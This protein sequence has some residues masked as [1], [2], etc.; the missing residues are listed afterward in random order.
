MIPVRVFT[1][2]VCATCPMAIRITRRL[3]DENPD[4]DL[5][6]VSLGSAR[7]REEAKAREV[8]SVPTVFVGPA[9]FTGVPDWDELLAALESQRT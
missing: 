7:G 5:R 4:V 2:P 3:A 9:R 8:L 1:H 6:I